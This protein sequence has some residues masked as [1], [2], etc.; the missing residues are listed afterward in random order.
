V[1]VLTEDA[2]V[3]CDH[4]AGVADVVPTQSLVTIGGR[5]V[6]VEPNPEGRPIKRCPNALP[7]IKPCQLT[8]AVKVGYSGH[9]SIM[10]RRVCLDSLQG[11]T[12]GTPPGTVHFKV[13]EPGQHWVEST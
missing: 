12:D 6:L 5:R 10:G 2:D 8:L 11:L 9:V 4:Q 1:K 7:G 3:R 13:I